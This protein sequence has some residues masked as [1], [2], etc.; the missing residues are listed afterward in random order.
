LKRDRARQ[1]AQ[2]VGNVE[3]SLA[4]KVSKFYDPAAPVTERGLPTEDIASL[5]RAEGLHHRL[6]HAHANEMLRFVNSVPGCGVSNSDVVLW[7]SVRQNSC[8]GCL[9]GKLKEHNRVKSTKPLRAEDP[10]AV[11]VADLMFVEGRFDKKLPVY[12]HVDVATK[13]RIVVPLKDKTLSSLQEAF[14]RVLSKHRVHGCMLKKLVFDRE[15]SI[16]AIDNHIEAAGVELVLKAAGQKVGIV[17]VDIRHIR[18]KARSVKAG[19]RDTYGYWPPNQFNLLLLDDVAAV[20][21]RIPK[22]EV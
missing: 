10:G 15:S 19:V 12:V 13:F 7:K 2:G 21:N 20:E 18:E 22:P 5:D 17:E 8:S 11:G 4:S 16:L 14:D 9:Q 6:E 1:L 3:K